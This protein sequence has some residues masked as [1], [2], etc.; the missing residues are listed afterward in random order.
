M[1]AGCVEAVHVVDRLMEQGEASVGARP[2][3][4][5]NPS[6]TEYEL[7]GII[8]FLERMREPYDRL[9][10]AA[11]PGPSWNIILYLMKNHLRGEN[12]TMS[13]LASAADTPFASAMRRIHT[14]IENGDI[15]LR[16]RG[17][18][19][20]PFFL[21]SGRKLVIGFTDYA[22][23]VK[24]LLAGTFV[25]KNGSGDVDDYYFS[26]SYLAGQIIPPIEIMEKDKQAGAGAALPAA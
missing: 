5:D 1:D 14:L 21:E 23:S 20:K 13:S 25:L 4:N 16:K 8:T 6:M 18:T 2:K 17:T 7:L 3:S 11:E 15:H 19:G 26:G 9:L 12:I 10:K 24:A 22:K